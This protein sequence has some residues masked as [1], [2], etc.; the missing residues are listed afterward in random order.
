M[1]LRTRRA[2]Q[3]VVFVR[4]GTAS[5][6]NASSPTPGPPPSS[7]GGPSVLSIAFFGGM[8]LGTFGLGCWQVQRYQ[9]KLGVAA[10]QKSKYLAEPTVLPECSSQLHVLETVSQLGGRRISTSGTYEHGKEVLLGPRSA[11]VG[12]VGDAAQGL[13]TNPQGY[14][15]VTPLKRI[16]GTVVFINRGWV[17]MNEKSWHRPS[18][19]VQVHAIVGSGEKPSTFSPVNSPKTRKLLWLEPAALL[20]ATGYNASD[21]STSVVPIILEAVEPDNVPVTSYPACRRV[22]HLNDQYITPMTHVVYA[23]TWFSLSAAGTIMTYYMFKKPTRL[24][25]SVRGPR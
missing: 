25:R 13:A 3:G 8:C 7:S 20:E 1:L 12:L 11:P 24:T 21:A 6:A 5:S 15:V 23:T 9:W 2:W 18:G 16:D 14:Y 4:R 10:E 17:A 22:K 19:V